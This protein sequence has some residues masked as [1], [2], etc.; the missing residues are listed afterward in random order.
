[1]GAI[2]NAFQLY[3]PA[4]GSGLPE[5]SFAE[6]VVS[7]Q[8]RTCSETRSAPF[9]LPVCHKHN[10]TDHA[11]CLHPTFNTTVTAAWYL[12]GTQK[13]FFLLPLFIRTVSSLLVRFFRNH[14][15]RT[16]FIRHVSLNRTVNADW[17]D[18]TPHVHVHA[19]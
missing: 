1:M 13:L 18:P 3:H 6:Y 4:E 19:N 12:L 8:N 17:A 9:R 14:Y 11:H 7:S 15:L 16:A 5:K 2:D 10:S